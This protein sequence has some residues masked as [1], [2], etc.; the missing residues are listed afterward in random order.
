MGDLAGREITTG[1]SPTG[2]RPVTAKRIAKN[3]TTPPQ[4]G[5]PLF[6]CDWVLANHRMMGSA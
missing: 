6:C 1:I 5:L 4:Q 2:E 3:G